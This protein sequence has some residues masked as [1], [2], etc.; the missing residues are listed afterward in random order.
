MTRYLYCLNSILKITEGMLSCP[1]FCLRITNEQ[2]YTCCMYFLE[3][4]YSVVCLGSQA[5]LIQAK[6][7]MM[8]PQVCIVLVGL[9]REGQVTWETCRLPFKVLL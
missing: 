4:E 8:F 9:G 2:E 5:A 7:I 6:K 1:L 3:T